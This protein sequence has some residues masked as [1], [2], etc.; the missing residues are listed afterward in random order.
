MHFGQ[1][2]H[3]HTK[4]CAPTVNTDK[5]GTI[6]CGDVPATVFVLLFIRYLGGRCALLYRLNVASAFRPL[7]C[8]S[9][10]FCSF[11][12]LCCFSLIL[13][14]PLGVGSVYTQLSYVL[15]P[16]LI[17]AQR[18]FSLALHCVFRRLELNSSWLSLSFGCFCVCSFLF[19]RLR[20]SLFV[21][22]SFSELRTRRYSLDVETVYGMIFLRNLP[23]LKCSLSLK[24][25]YY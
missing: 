1:S 6:Q 14:R 8:Y 13:T 5:I 15:F 4:R 16:V 23:V 3:P 7:R 22:A 20:S 2:M 19:L 11:C 9:H 24:V 12:I 18:R 25:Y 21:G 10:T 17:S